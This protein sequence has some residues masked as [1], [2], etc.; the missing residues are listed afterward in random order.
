MAAS[1][2]HL[3]FTSG[4]GVRITC[5]LSFCRTGSSSMESKSRYLQQPDRHP[6]INNTSCSF[7]AVPKNLKTTYKPALNQLVVLSVPFPM[8]SSSPARP[9]P[10]CWLSAAVTCHVVEVVLSSVVASCTGADARLILLDGIDPSQQPPRCRG[11]ARWCCC[12]TRLRA[13]WHPSP[14]TGVA[15]LLGRASIDTYGSTTL[16]GLSPI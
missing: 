10:S 7:P 8:L 6:M 3:L 5:I 15:Q 1:S 4:S 2:M 11:W 14:P 13:I 12:A 16:T 9:R